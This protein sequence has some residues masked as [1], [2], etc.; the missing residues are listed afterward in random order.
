MTISDLL[1]I[2]NPL[3]VQGRTD[4][5][6]SGIC[7]NSKKVKPGDLFLAWKGENSN[8]IDSIVREA[9]QKG[10]IAIVTEEQ[11]SPPQTS[12]TLIHAQ[13]LRKKLAPIAAQFY[14]HPDNDLHLIAITGTNGKTT[15]AF[16]TQYL[17]NHIGLRCGLIGT[18][19]YDLGD[20]ILPASRTTPEGND[21]HEMFAIMKKTGIRAAAIEVSSHALDQGRAEGIA[22]DTA[23]FMNLTPDHLDYHGT[24]ENYYQ[25]K[26][27]LF[28][29]LSQSPKPS[30]AAI[31]NTDDPYGKRL[32]Q[33]L[34]QDIAPYPVFTFGFQA[35]STP[36]FLASNHQ[37]SS[38][39]QSFS[40]HTPHGTHHI[41]LPLLGAYNAYNAIAAI[42]AASIQSPIPHLI[43]ALK[44]APNVPGR[45]QTLSAGPSGPTI[46]VDYAHTPDAVEKVLHTLRTLKPPRLTIVI[47][48]GGNRDRSKRPLMA[49]AAVCHA[50]HAFFTADNPRYENLEDI[51]NDMAQGATSHQKNNYTIIPDRYQAIQ[52]AIT[53]AIPNEIILIA[54]KG[55]ETT[56]QIG[57]TFYPFNDLQVAREIISTLSIS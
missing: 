27:R 7:Y 44:Q 55:H 47:G 23:V 45:M 6:I 53:Q 33:E 19:H 37:T 4:E 54:G 48:C 1:P 42:A 10:A 39:G 2:L 22:F 13:N 57:S 46:I 26:K 12:A 8:N 30:R 52:K 56:Q 41:T 43:E 35:E 31:I 17:F 21:L 18:V 14:N 25:A 20:K 40:L 36:H 3:A 38:Q 15:T 51:L 29:L 49:Q 11:P 5:K 34:A 50:D 9:A 24:I 16:L 28:S 32:A